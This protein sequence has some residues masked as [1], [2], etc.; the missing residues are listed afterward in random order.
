MPK[1]LEVDARTLYNWLASGARVISGAG[2]GI[3]QTALVEYL[4]DALRLTTSNNSVQLQLTTPIEG[5]HQAAVS[6]CLPMTQPKLFPNDKLGKWLDYVT[7]PVLL[8]W[9]AESLVLTLKAAKNKMTLHCLAAEAYPTWAVWESVAAVNVSGETLATLVK[10]TAF[11][12]AEEGTSVSKPGLEGVWLRPDLGCAVSSDGN[13]VVFAGDYQSADN[14]V[15]QGAVIPKTTWNLVKNIFGVAETVAYESN[16]RGVR[17]ETQM[18]AESLRLI[19]Q[20]LAVPFPNM[21]A[22]MRNSVAKRIAEQTLTV[23]VL[24]ASELAKGLNAALTFSTSNSF[25]KVG[26]RPTADTLWLS[27]VDAETGSVEIAVA[28]EFTGKLTPI[29]I[30]GKYLQEGLKPLGDNLIVLEFGN[31]KQALTF[32]PQETKDYLYLAAPMTGG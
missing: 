28:G 8:S 19:G 1:L 10:R 4:P 14:V 13:S 25:G 23:G 29:F 21:F 20:R 11:A 7:G 9:D 18:G 26:L 27:G 15:D 5:L 31:A 32:E 6:F 12:V 17:F 24:R 30:S 3:W 16:Q 2:E 22:L